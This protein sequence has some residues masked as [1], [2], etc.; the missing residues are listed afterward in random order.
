MNATLLAADVTSAVA[1][2]APVL[3]SSTAPATAKEAEAKETKGTRETRPDAE[4]PNGRYTDD[5]LEGESEGTPAI[6]ASP[7]PSLDDVLGSVERHREATSGLTFVP[8]VVRALGASHGHDPD[9]VHAAL[10]YA[11]SAGVLELRPESGM[12]RLSAEDQML[13][14]PGPRGSRLSWVRRVDAEV[15]ERRDGVMS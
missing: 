1:A 8:T 2:F 5:A 15:E 6:H 11:A 9:A 14:L 3:R 13:C 7:K 10:L 12:G 4:R